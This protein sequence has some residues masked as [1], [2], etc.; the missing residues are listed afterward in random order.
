MERLYTAF[1]EAVRTGGPS[2]VPGPEILRIQRLMDALYESAAR[3]REVQIRAGTEPRVRRPRMSLIYIEYFSRRP[4]VDLDA[5]RA[6]VAEGQQGWDSGYDADRLV[7]NAGRTWRL[8]PEPE[9]FAAWH[10]PRSGFDRLDDW[11]RIF[12]GGEADHLEGAFF[13]VARID[14]AGCYAPLIEPVHTR[15][16]HLLRRVLPPP[17]RCGSDLRLLRGAEPQA[18]PAWG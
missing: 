4:G 12:R 2:P 13:R 15:G 10:C 18:P 16:R 7:L 17:R 14:V 3:Q 5:F 11:D 8:G 1:L 9:Y 6:G